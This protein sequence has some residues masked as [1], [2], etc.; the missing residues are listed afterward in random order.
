M[1]DSSFIANADNKKTFIKC[2][3]FCNDQSVA[4]LLIFYSQGKYISIGDHICLSDYPSDL[5]TFRN[6]YRQV[7]P[8]NIIHR[9]V[10]IVFQIGKC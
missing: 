8:L 10:L 5:R 4:A 1:D 6:T 2:K 7:L 3:H 9:V